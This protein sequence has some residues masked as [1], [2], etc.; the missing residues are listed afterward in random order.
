[1]RLLGRNI[2]ART[3]PNDYNI[4]QHP[5]M[6]REKFDRTIFKFEPTSRNMVAFSRL[7]VVG[8]GERRAREKM[9]EG[10]SS[11]VFSSLR[12]SL[13]T[14]RAL[15]RL[16]HGGQTRET[17]STQQCCVEMLRSFGRDFTFDWM[18]KQREFCKPCNGVMQK[19]E[20]LL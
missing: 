11:L 4:M 16:Q 15:N 13:T 3:W 14:E 5:K 2:V 6:L 17:C 18:K 10:M 1:M 19:N 12:S 7:S 20:F 9:R 8:D